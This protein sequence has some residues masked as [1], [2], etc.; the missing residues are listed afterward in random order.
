[1]LSVGEEIQDG[2]LAEVTHLRQGAVIRRCSMTLTTFAHQN[3]IRG[4]LPS[5]APEVQWVDDRLPG[6][7]Y[8]LKYHCAGRIACCGCS[9]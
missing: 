7:A 5:E 9:S 4:L 3:K 2:V 1:M 6:A 8:R